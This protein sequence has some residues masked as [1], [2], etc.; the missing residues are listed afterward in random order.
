M[1]VPLKCTDHG[2]VQ[3][4]LS[5]RRVTDDSHP[6]SAFLDAECGCSRM[7]PAGTD[8]IGACPD[9]GPWEIIFKVL[10]SGCRAH[11]WVLLA[12]GCQGNILIDGAVSLF[13]E[14]K[15]IT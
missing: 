10:C 1:S 14:G 9:H 5:P 3:A 6:G 2:L 12:C 11:G 4:K 13:T 7:V 8:A 15:H